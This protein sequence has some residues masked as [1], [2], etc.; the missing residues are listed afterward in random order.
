M[1]KIINEEVTNCLPCQANTDTTH[2]DF[3]IPSPFP[4]TKLG[5]TSI[6]FSSQ[7]PTGEYILVAYNEAGRLSTLKLSRSLTAKDA[8]RI[9]M[10]TFEKLGTPL[11]V[12]SDN[13]RAFASHEFA[14]F[15]KQRGFKHR[16][17]CPLNPQAD[18]VCERFMK[19]INK[20]IRCAKVEKVPW[21]N[22][23]GKMIRNYCATPLRATGISPNFFIHG[24][25]DFDNIPTVRSEGNLEEILSKARSK[26]QI[27]KQKMKKYAD[28]SQHAKKLNFHIGEP[29]L[30]KWDR[31][32]KHQALFDPNPYKLIHIKGN[33]LS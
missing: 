24:K 31:H 32:N 10:E 3:M 9:C 23:T 25:D 11:E 30:V 12:K 6:D 18:G 29:V 26:D 19:T 2:H 14:E 15:A 8:I 13:G 5:L 17:I 28:F 20:S 27:Y 1:E 21:K 22:V 7:T 16:K 33:M 4:S